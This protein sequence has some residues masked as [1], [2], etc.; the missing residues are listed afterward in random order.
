M[1]RRGISFE[2]DDKVAG[3]DGIEPLTCTA[4]GKRSPLLFLDNGAVCRNPNRAA[5]LYRAAG[6]RPAFS[7]NARARKPQSSK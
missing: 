1:K 3:A 4:A 6:Q 5:A 7:N 2:P